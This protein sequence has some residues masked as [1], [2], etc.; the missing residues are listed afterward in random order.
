M[1][2]RW[3][4][5]RLG[6]TAAACSPGPDEQVSINIRQRMSRVVPLFG[7]DKG[8]QVRCPLALSPPMYLRQCALRTHP[9]RTRTQPQVQIA[10]E[11][12]KASWPRTPP[13]A[14]ANIY[15][16]FFNVHQW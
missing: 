13:P 15:L 2:S 10:V 7:L 16:A 4:A 12:A 6:A 8:G 5:C 9:E 1:A 3:L 11:V 14:W